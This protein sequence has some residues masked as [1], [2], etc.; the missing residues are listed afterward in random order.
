MKRLP[1]WANIIMIT[2]GVIVCV[3]LLLLTYCGL[4]AL[5]T[6]SG[7]VDTLSNTWCTIFSISKPLPVEEIVEATI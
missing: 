5:F 3:G 2:L 6:G 4:S 7:F 1:L